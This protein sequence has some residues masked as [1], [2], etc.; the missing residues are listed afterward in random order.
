IQRLW[1]R[2]ESKIWTRVKKKKTPEQK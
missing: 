2:Q 1:R